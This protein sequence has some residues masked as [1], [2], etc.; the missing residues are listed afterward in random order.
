MGD[1]AL[2]L[3]CFLVA[4]LRAQ[5]GPT[6]PVSLP[7][8]ATSVAALGTSSASTSSAVPTVPPTSSTQDALG[9][10]VTTAAAPTPL[11]K[12]TSSEPTEEAITSP[13]PSQEGTNPTPSA[14]GLSSTAAGTP[15]ALT[16]E[17][18]SLGGPGASMPATGWQSPT[19]LS[20]QDV[21]SSS[22]SLSTPPPP[23]PSASVP[24]NHS[25]QVP[26]TQAPAAPTTPAPPTEK[27]SSSHTAAPHT[28]VEPGAK[29][30]TAQ[31]AQ[32]GK[33]ICGPETT[34]PFLIMQEVGHALSSG[35]VAAITVTVIAVVVLVFGVAAYLKIRHSSYGRLLDDHDYG[36]WGN[37][38][39]P[40]YDDS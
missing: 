2:V 6:S 32:P 12:N 7:A 30:N 5:S 34:T 10:P 8:R 38:N 1:R 28:T 9:L 26:S 18:H 4:G 33:G 11:P 37:Y 17:E 31:D 24:S 29:E 19:P 16:P 21:A 36:S 15:S 20:A 27:P 14:P 13:A 39:N 22:S 35:S 40:L 23:A 3:L 25:T